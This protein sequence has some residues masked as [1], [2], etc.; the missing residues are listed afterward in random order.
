L[1]GLILEGFGNTEEDGGFDYDGGRS[2]KKTPF[3]LWS[4][5]N[6]LIKTFL[7]D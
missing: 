1:V 7:P 4:P 5:L 3:K 2:T 6:K